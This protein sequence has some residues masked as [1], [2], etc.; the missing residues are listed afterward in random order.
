[1]YKIL[2]KKQLTAVVHLMEVESPWIALHGLPG[3]FVIVIPTEKGERVPLTIAD[4]NK[5]RQSVTIIFQVVGDSTRQLSAMRTGESLYTIA[6]PLGR[7]VSI[8]EGYSGRTLLVA[9][10]VGTAPVYP[11]AKWLHSHG[12]QCDVVMGARNKDI[13]FFTDEMA[14]VCDNLYLMTDD[15]SNGHKGLVTDKVRE[16]VESGQHYDLCIAIGPMVMMKFVAQLTRELNLPTQVSLDCMMVDGTGMCG[17]CRVT[18]D[19]KVRFTCMDGPF[20][21]GHH[22]DYDE[23]RRHLARPDEQKYR[24][25]TNTPD[26]H[27]NL[28]SAVDQALEQAALSGPKASRQHPQEQDPTRRAHNFDEVSHG[29]TPAQAAIEAS[30]CL[31]CKKPMC[32][33]HCPVGIQIPQFISAIKQGQIAEAERIIKMDSSL[34]A[35]CGRV[36]PQENQCE[37]S[38]I[39]GK[40]GEPIAIG[41]LERYVADTMRNNPQLRTAPTPTPTPN[42]KKIAIIGSG[43]SGLACANDLA[44]KGYAVT[45]FEALHH[46]GGVLVYGIPEF[47]LPKTRVVEPEIDGLRQLGVDIQTNVIIGKSITIDELLDNQGY[48]AVYVASGA[49]LPR[50]MGIPG[51]ELVGV[52]SANELLTRTNLM[53]GYDTEYAT[54]IYLGERVAVIG[55]GNVA[56]DAARTAL[57]LGSKVT[58]VYRRSE[59]EMPARREELHHAQQEGIEFAYLTNPI[60][61]LN[62]GQGNVGGMRLQRMELGEPDERGR[63]SPI[64]VEGS[65][66]TLPFETIIM[67]LG[68]SPNP[69]IKDTTPGLDTTSR[70][71]IAIDET[72][73]QTSRRGV[74]AGG[75]AVTGAATVIL[76]MG[77]GRQAAQA[78]DQYLNS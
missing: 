57:R 4:I 48:A 5:E 45:I 20:F 58:V 29:F 21:D 9:G 37:G 1:M 69:Q 52:Y 42:G 46:A 70:G 8:L 74:F 59:A 62:D 10:G 75:D 55:G 71:G 14:A 28:A 7:P 78:I 17:A 23:A 19:G 18:V 6:G 31:Q 63:R 43:P 68:T 25:A 36:C 12:L 16:L 41:N 67:A 26:H 56:M 33:Q 2:N 61:I 73:R 15:G 24:I 65:E 13:F 64:P 40:K 77:A 44:K 66:Y 34:P 53:H 11:I 76:A 3:Q 72:T 49:G 51:E 30:R 50:F 47:R 35:I 54:P 38:C 22:V 60:E 32:V 39:M 27:C